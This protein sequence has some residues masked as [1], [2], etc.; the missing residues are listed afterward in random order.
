MTD[1]FKVIH[2]QQTTLLIGFDSA[3][4]A[5]NSGA[6]AGVLR[7]D[8]GKFHELGLPQIM[9]YPKAEAVILRWQAEE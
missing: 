2:E 7:S 4:T 1:G 8:N 3:W 9:D 5:D 6:L